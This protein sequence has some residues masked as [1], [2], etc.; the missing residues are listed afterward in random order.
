MANTF[1]Q[2]SVGRFEVAIITHNGDLVPQPD[3]F[4]TLEAIFI[5]PDTGRVHTAI[6]TTT[7]LEI[8]P[9]RY[10]LEWQVPFDQPLLVHQVIN[11]GFI[12]EIPVIGEDIFTVL[13]IEPTC[14]RSPTLL[15]K[16]N[17]GC[18]CRS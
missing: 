13:P 12:D 3:G 2:N 9:G 5:H 15:T 8:E 11:R 7:M 4:P 1:R 10:F 6:P 16:L 14:L 18:G 17:G